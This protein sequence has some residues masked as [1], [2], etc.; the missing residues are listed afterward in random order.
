MKAFVLI[1]VLL[2]PNASFGQIA[3][4][5]IENF[6]SLV[7]NVVIE[8]DNAIGAAFIVGKNDKEVFLVTAKHVL[9]GNRNV[10]L[11]S[12]DGSRNLASLVEEH[13]VYDLALL[14][15]SSVALNLEEIPIIKDLS[16]NDEVVFI[17][18]K[19]S[20]KIFPANSRGI[21]RDITGEMLHVLMAGVE[22]GHSGSPVLNEDGI[23]GMIL[24]N[25]RTIECLNILQ[26]NEIVH[27]W[28]GDQFKVILR[29]QATKRKSLPSPGSLV[30]SEVREVPIAIVKTDEKYLSN[31]RNLF[32]ENLSTFW[33]CSGKLNETNTLEFYFHRGS[34][35]SHFDIF[36]SN[37]LSTELPKG[38][39]FLYNDGTVSKVTFQ[40]ILKSK[41]RDGTGFWFTYVFKKPIPVSHLKFEFIHN[42]EARST[43]SLSEIKIFGHTL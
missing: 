35:I 37:D 26:V 21:V 41:T 6:K 8:N 17:S 27:D 7:F 3:L 13:H 16:I 39:I 14:K 9:R 12:V 19:D 22:P 36:I 31:L 11:T 34:S 40:S 33:S 18:M 43:I 38:K 2:I 28:C 15:S 42:N 4:S 29:E 32:D 20:G 30:N 23:A 1:M 5:S 24:K 10:I 25:G